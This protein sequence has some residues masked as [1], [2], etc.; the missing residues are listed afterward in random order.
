MKKQ[1]LFGGML[2]LAAA[3]T[4]CTEDFKNWAS[5]QTNSPE[6]AITIP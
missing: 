4:G 5:P 3:F 1:I 6:D 2:L